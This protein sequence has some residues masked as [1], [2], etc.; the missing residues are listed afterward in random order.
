M[1]FGRTLEIIRSES[2]DAGLRWLVIGGVALAAHGVTRATLDLDLLVD[3]DR[4]ESWIALVEGLGYD[5]RHRSAGYST[6]D[7]PESRRGRL[8]I[9]YVRGESRKRLFNAAESKRGPGGIE[10]AVPKPEHL[11]ALKAMAIRNDPDRALQDLADIRALVRR[12]GIEQGEVRRIFERYQIDERYET[13]LGS[14]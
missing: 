12:H 6:H 8:D 9:V 2:E 14:A 1:D 13:Y 10:I 4:Q 3:G 7:H 5:T 11:I